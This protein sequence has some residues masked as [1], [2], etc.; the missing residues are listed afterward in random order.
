MTTDSA[1]DTS[2]DPDEGPI[3][4]DAVV[5][6]VL[7]HAA[8]LFAE[9]GPAATSIRDIAKRAG[10]NHGLV[11]RHLGAKEQLVAAVLNH[12]A[13]QTA[14]RVAAGPVSAGDPTMR[15]QWTVL[16]RAILDGYPVG[17]LQQHFPTVDRVVEQARKHH[18]DERSADLAA[19]NALALVLGWQLFEPFLRF[20]TGLQDVPEPELRSAIE[21]AAASVM[22]LP[23]P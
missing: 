8:D 11:F 4:R 16:A 1:T 2:P 10:V 12:L 22:G 20:A 3:G 17:E 7:E 19:A 6:A 15:R 5:A 21:T 14:L 9:R 18:P 13:D 23:R